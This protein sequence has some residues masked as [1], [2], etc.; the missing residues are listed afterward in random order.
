MQSEDHRDR[1]D[2][3]PQEDLE[4]RPRPIVKVDEARTER[5]SGDHIHLTPRAQRRMAMGRR[6][7]Y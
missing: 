3:T 1:T 7:G 6:S 4:S 2:S 5:L